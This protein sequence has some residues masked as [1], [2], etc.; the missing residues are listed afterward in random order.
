[1]HVHPMSCTP[2]QARSNEVVSI[3]GAA[4]GTSLPFSFSHT[5][6]DSVGELSQIPEGVRA[7]HV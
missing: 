6:L 2:T 5:V 7:R 1:M 4:E 3:P